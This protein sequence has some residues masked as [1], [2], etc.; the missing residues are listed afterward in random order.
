M[1]PAG[2]NQFESVED[3]SVSIVTSVHGENRPLNSE[4]QTD[5]HIPESGSE[6]KA[7]EQDILL[8]IQQ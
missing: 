4:I 2:M 8:S 5:L 3:P 1:I 7:K 6:S